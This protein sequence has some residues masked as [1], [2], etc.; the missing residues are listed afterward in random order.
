MVEVSRDGR[1]IYIS[2][3]LYKSWDEQFYPERIRGWV[4]KIDAEPAGGI[5]VLSSGKDVKSLPGD[6]VTQRFDLRPRFDVLRAR[7][8]AASILLGVEHDIDF[9]VPVAATVDLRR[10]VSFE[11]LK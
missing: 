9:V 8:P 3:S 10:T 4:A 5:N 2:N 11:R 1:R 6:S 7:H